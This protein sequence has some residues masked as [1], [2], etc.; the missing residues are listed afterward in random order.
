MAVLLEPESFI[1][2]E[3]GQLKKIWKLQLLV[4]IMENV[5][6]HDRI[7]GAILINH[8][9]CIQVRSLGNFQRI[10]LYS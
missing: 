9:E 5:P 7:L 1:L 6:C 2:P 8:Q 4:L 3:N 10:K